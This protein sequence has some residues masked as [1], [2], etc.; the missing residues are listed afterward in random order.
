MENN[1]F[2]IFNSDENLE[3]V[4]KAN[5][6]DKLKEKLAQVLDAPYGYINEINGIND[7]DSIIDYDT[8]D[9]SIVFE[10]DDNSQV[11]TIQRIEIY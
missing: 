9:F 1:Y 8:H 10:D 4:A 5:S 3:G 11:F 6:T 7:I 2:A